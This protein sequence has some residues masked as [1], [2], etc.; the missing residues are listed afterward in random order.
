MNRNRNMN[1]TSDKVNRMT[2]LITMIAI[3]SGA[4][5]VARAGEVSTSASATGNA[6]GPGT[7]AA[8]AGYSGNGPGYAHTDTRTGNVNFASGVAWGVDNRGV[9][10][11]ASNALAG[12]VGPALASNL[13]ICIGLDGSVASSGG[14]AAAR[15]GLTRSVSAGGF[16]RSQF[17]G[18][19]ASS[20]V[21]ART[22]PRG[23]ASGRT[24]SNSTPRRSWW[25]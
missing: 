17:G 18:G 3:V 5:V 12:R 15:G 4:A 10:F 16:A 2:R 25:R 11:S 9:C 20:M 19:V 21:G 6:W 14:L 1:T 23:F 22:D 7:A 13:N 24:W 8:T